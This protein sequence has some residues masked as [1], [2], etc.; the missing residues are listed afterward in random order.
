MR[1]QEAGG[2][3]VAAAV[4]EVSSPTILAPA[5]LLAIA[6]DQQVRHGR[7]AV[8]WGLLAGIAAGVIPLIFLRMGVRKG[9]WSDHHVP[10]R[11]SRVLPLAVAVCSV[12]AGI[13]LLLIGHAPR[14]ISALVVAM[15][16]GLLA[17]LAVS[18]FWKV[19]IHSAVAGGTAVILTATF[20]VI[21][22]AIGLVVVF[23]A[24]W[25]RVRLG[26]HSIAQVVVG[27]AVGAAAATTFLPLR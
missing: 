2:D 11:E 5:L 21:G 15:L 14:A 10:A 16:V 12:A 17:V 22:L 6:L 27:A 13:A 18:L 23:G 4:T 19:S 7:D 9:R 24:A 20:G 25:S 26:D 8:L 3:R 1:A